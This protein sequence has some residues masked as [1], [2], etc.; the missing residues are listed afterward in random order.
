MRLQGPTLSS[1]SLSG[2][3]QASLREFTAAFAMQDSLPTEKS[4]YP[5]GGRRCTCLPI[6]MVMIMER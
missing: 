1:G 3:P 6:L 2:F 5:S 4:A